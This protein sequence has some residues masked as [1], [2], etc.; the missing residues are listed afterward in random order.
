MRNSLNVNVQPVSASIPVRNVPLKQYKIDGT[1]FEPKISY[2]DPTLGKRHSAHFVRQE[3][4]NKFE[5]SYGFPQ[6]MSL[7]ISHNK[8]PVQR[9][10]S[11]RQT[12]Q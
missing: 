7:A 12:P 10:S 6:T 9:Q 8:V 1:T 3:E 2:N 11:Q 5:K 4:L